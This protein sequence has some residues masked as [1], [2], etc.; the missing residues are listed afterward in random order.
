MSV[1]NIRGNIHH[2]SQAN[3]MEEQ[4]HNGKGKTRYVHIPFF[5]V[6]FFWERNSCR[7]KFSVSNTL[8]WQGRIRKF[9]HWRQNS[10]LSLILA[11][12]SGEISKYHL[13]VV[14]RAKL[15]QISALQLPKLWYW[16]L[17][18]GNGLPQP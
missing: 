11:E 15:N 16:Y 9:W 5:L 18:F 2:K 7:C 4:V 12:N 10:T 3:A 17:F 14:S 8:A 13:L 6:Q 1:I